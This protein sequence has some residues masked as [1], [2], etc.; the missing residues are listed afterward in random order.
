MRCVFVSPDGQAE[1]LWTPPGDNPD[2]APYEVGAIIASVGN[3]ECTALLPGDRLLT[4]N[5]APVTTASGRCVSW[6]RA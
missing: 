4:I 1:K 3:P 2:E 5:G 6:L